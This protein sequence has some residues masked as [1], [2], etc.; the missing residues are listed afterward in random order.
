MKLKRLAGVGFLYMCGCFLFTRTC[1]ASAVDVYIAQSAAGADNGSN[2]A[3]AHASTFFNTL[4][5][6]GAGVTQIGAGTTVHICG[7]ITA[8]SSTTA[9]TFQQSGALGNP[10]TLLFEAD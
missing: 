4:A 2:C 9:L 1:A 3:N 7:T 8:P 5:N 10:V 6:W